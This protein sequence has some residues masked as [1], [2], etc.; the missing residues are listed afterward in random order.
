MAVPPDAELGRDEDEPIAPEIRRGAL[1]VRV[2]AALLVLVAIVA[3]ALLGGFDQV[4][5]A[6]STPVLVAAVDEEINAGPWL[7]TIESAQIGH[8]LREYGPP[9]D[10]VLQ[11]NVRIAVVDSHT[12]S[13]LDAIS[14]DENTPGVTEP[15]STTRF[16]HDN[17]LALEA[18]PGLPVRVAFLWI[19]AKGTAV[20]QDVTVV[21]HGYIRRYMNFRFLGQTI[22]KES[23]QATVKVPLLDRTETT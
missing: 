19:I 1:I 15:D 11:V 5:N 3:A 16:L 6:S 10:L 14:L 2:E 7:I 18:Q 12:R 8:R 9:E 17:T 22:E 4:G 23:P 13:I 20:P 21:V